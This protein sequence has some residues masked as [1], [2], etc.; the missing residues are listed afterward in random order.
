MRVSLFILALLLAACDDDSPK[1]SI[2]ETGPGSTSINAG[3]NVS[4]CNPTFS[5]NLQYTT[6]KIECG[7][8]IPPAALAKLEDY[9]NEQLR[10][11]KNQND[12]IDRLRKETADWEQRFRDQETN[13]REGLA[14]MPNDELLKAAQLALQQGDLEQAAQLREQR[15]LQ[16]EE[17]ATAK[18]AAEA[19]QVGKAFQLAFKPL[20]ALPYLEKAYRYQPANF[21]Y[22]FAY[23]TALAKQNQ[24]QQAEAVYQDLLTAARADNG[25]P[26]RVA[27]LLNNL[28]I[29]V[30]ADTHRRGEAEKQYQ[31]ALKIF[32][33][34][35]KD[36]P[37]VYRPDVAMTLNNLANLVQADTRR[38][39]EAEKLYQ[40]AL[41]ISRTLAKDNPS[42]YLPVVAMTLN[43]LAILIDDDTQRRGKAEKQYQESLDIYLSLAKDNPKG[44]LP[45]VA[46]TLNNL[47]LLVAADT[48]TRGEAEKLY[49]DSLDIYR[50]LAKDNPAV[51]RPYVAMTLTNLGILVSDDT[52]RRGEAEKQYQE[53]LDIY[54]SLAKDNPAV[55]RPYVAKTLNNLGLLVSY[56]TRRRG[57]AEKQYREALEI[58]RSLAKDNPSVYRPDVAMT[59]NNLANLVSDDTRRRVEAEKQYR[60]ALDIRRSLAK[61]HPSVFEPH[62]VDTL[63]AFGMAQLQWQDKPHARVSLQ[64][65]AHILRPYAQQAPGVFGDEQAYTLFL[66]AQASE[67]D[68]QACLAVEEGLGFAQSDETK[69]MLTPAHA[70]CDEISALA[71]PSAKPKPR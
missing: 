27:T 58:L 24:R 13:L 28:A 1:Q 49:Q 60:E 11:S 3:G 33:S 67:N 12:Y 66:L 70:I 35:A 20:Q 34:L 53:S 36:N 8:G 14:L 31:E 64:E 37:S 61:G 42:V 2:S 63:G 48:R 6:V 55:Y 17:K 29:L 69:A 54:R 22:G 15:Y 5:G 25:K 41:D 44:Y 47:G 45:Y 23:A 57:E 38:R 9:L 62:L 51:Y 18:L 71:K 16:W 59:L 46:G 39:D 30:K 56:D 32:R 50:S 7:P 21:D 52:R 43:N 10:T 65:A 4:T 40:E 68:T 26:K 19:F